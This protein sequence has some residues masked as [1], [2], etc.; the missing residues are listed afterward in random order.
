MVAVPA[1]TPVTTPVEPTVAAAVLVLVQT[2]PVVVLVNEVV[3][4]AHT[5]PVPVIVPAEGNG[6]TATVA[7]IWQPVGNV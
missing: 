5:V 2:P 3:A 4:A 6:F 1:A 7:L